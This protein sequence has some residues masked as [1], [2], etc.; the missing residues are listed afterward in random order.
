[1]LRLLFLYLDNQKPNQGDLMWASYMAGMWTALI[2]ETVV[3]IFHRG[4]VCP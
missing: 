3:H 1:M 2:I 4:A